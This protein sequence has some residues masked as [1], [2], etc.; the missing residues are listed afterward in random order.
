MVSPLSLE[1]RRYSHEQRQQHAPQPR[2]NN[3]GSERTW[4]QSHRAQGLSGTVTQRA[5]DSADQD[6]Q[7]IASRH[8]LEGIIQRRRKQTSE[9]DQPRRAEPRSEWIIHKQEDACSTEDTIEQRPQQRHYATDSSRCRRIHR[10]LDVESD[11]TGHCE[12]TDPGMTPSR[13]KDGDPPSDLKDHHIGEAASHPAREFCRQPDL[14]NKR[15]AVEIDRSR[16]PPS[17]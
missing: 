3:E 1:E 8:P 13:A 6:R 2:Q 17:Q 16:N 5:K 10:E 7:P 12:R 11:Q 14:A 15:C 9:S 4:T